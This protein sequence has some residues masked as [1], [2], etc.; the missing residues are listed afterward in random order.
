MKETE[1]TEDEG[2]DDSRNRFEF[3]LLFFFLSSLDRLSTR[4]AA[5]FGVCEATKKLHV[6][7]SAQERIP[8]LVFFIYISDATQFPTI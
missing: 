8:S 3:I 6:D 2:D 5:G 7:C 4:V 1:V